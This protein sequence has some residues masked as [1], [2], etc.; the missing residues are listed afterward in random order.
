MEQHLV[1]QISLGDNLQCRQ[2]H[3]KLLE[4]DGD[5]AL[6]YSEVCYWNQQFLMGPE[7]VEDARRTARAPDFSVQLRIQSALE[8]M[9]LASV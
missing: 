8:E 9:P 6:S 3:F 2:I 5:D 7:Y 4:L 1:V